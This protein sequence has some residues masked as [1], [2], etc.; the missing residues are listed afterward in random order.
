MKETNPAKK[1]N[2]QP[3]KSQ[4]DKKKPKKKN[5]AA[6]KI[7]IESDSLPFITTVRR[8]ASGITGKKKSEKKVPINTMTKQIMNTIII[9]R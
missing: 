2:S 7:V 5:S 8:K 6:K 4:P 9:R 3:P 1:N